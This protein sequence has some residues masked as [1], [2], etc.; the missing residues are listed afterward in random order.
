MAVYQEQIGVSIVVVIKEPQPPSAQH[1]RRRSDLSGLA[2]ENQVLLFVIKT[3]KLS[4]DV[5]HEKIL[6]AIAIIV[7]RV[8]SHPRARFACVA[9]AHARRQ[10]NFF[11]F[12]APL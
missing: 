12:P 8:N 5:G 6:P 11:E 3:E 4:I 2:R 7:P 10:S 9:V 1:L